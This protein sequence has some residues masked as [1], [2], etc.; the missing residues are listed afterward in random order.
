MFAKITQSSIETLDA[1]NKEHIKFGKHPKKPSCLDAKKTVKTWKLETRVLASA[2]QTT[3][4]SRKFIPVPNSMKIGRN[5]DT[6]LETMVD[7]LWKGGLLQWK[8]AQEYRNTHVHAT[9]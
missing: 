6:I 1:D 8:A 5:A 4:W 3:I 9:V 7:K 2:L